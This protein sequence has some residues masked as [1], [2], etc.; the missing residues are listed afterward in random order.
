MGQSRKR[1]Q[2]HR[3]LRT[4]Q[5]I[6]QVAY[7]ERIE[8]AQLPERSWQLEFALC[9]KNILYEPVDDTPNERRVLIYRLEFGLPVRIKSINA[10]LPLAHQCPLPACT[11]S[12]DAVSWRCDVNRPATPEQSAHSATHQYSTEA[13]LL[14]ILSKRVR[15]GVY[16]SP[17]FDCTLLRQQWLLH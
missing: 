3:L 6:A 2:R 14:C 8:V 11:S 16:A 4:L 15:T 7:Y 10:S 1:E 13:V 17:T 12:A 9:C 5:H